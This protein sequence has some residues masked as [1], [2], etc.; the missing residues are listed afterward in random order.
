VSRGSNIVLA[1]VCG[2]ACAGDD[3][4]LPQPTSTAGQFTSDGTSTTGGDED[5]GT[6]TSEGS[7]DGSTT[8]TSGTPCLGEGCPC[9]EAEADP[10]PT[11]LFCDA[12]SCTAVACGDGIVAG[13]EVC[14]DGNTADGDGCDAD[15]TYTE[16]RIDASFLGTCALIEGGRVRCWGAGD[17]GQN[18]YGNTETIG[19]DEHPYEVGDVMLSGPLEQLQSGD[20]HVCGLLKDEHEVMCWGAGA[21][22]ALGYGNTQDIGDDEFLTTLGSVDVGAP[23]SFVTS[24]GT[25][26][27]VIT[28]AGQ[29]KCWGAEGF[30]EL[31]QGP[32][33]MGNIG[34]DE[35]PL[36]VGNVQI[37][38]AIVGLSAGIGQTCVITSTGAIKCWGLGS[39]GQLGYGN[40]DSIGDD[41]APATVQPL[42]FGIDALQISAGFAHTC[43][44]FEGGSVRCWGSS[45]NG[46]LGQGNTD[47]LGDA[48]PA[49]AG[50]PVPL[51]F[52]DEVVEISAGDFHSCALSSAGEMACWGSNDAGQLGVGTTDDIGDDEPASAASLVEFDA[53]IRQIDAGGSHTCAVLE[54]YRVYCWGRNGAGQ[55]GLGHT[56]DVGDDELPADAGEVLVLPPPR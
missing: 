49:T 54:D 52:D 53:P 34:D 1:L 20:R 9:D 24:G 50:S 40:T 38:A 30:G 39:D 14:D 42:Q 15:C 7:A 21:Q 5:P 22:G 19:D 6:T 8:G 32:A 33:H 47:T 27:C 10:C 16:I 26:T 3:S 48:V 45:F 25:H 44:L 56:D 12:G 37:G 4:G 46:Q 41:E 28:T 29:V 18:G 11:G 55:L 31:G 51:P 13:A 36:D 35:R 43:A 17:S 2:S 23:V